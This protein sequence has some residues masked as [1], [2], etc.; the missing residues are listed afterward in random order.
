MHESKISGHRENISVRFACCNI[1][2]AANA[3]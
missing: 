2:E 1:L 3:I